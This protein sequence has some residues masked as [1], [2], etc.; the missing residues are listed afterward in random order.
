VAAN[1]QLVLLGGGGHCRSC[2]D[3]VEAH[4]GWTI[5]GI[6]DVPARI[7]ERVF[8][9]EI[10]GSDE[11]IGQ[12]AKRGIAFFVT[13]GQI[14]SPDR[15][16]ALYEK[17]RA[18]AGKMPTLVSPHAYVSPRAKL[19]SGTVVM[20]HATVNCGAVVGANVIVNSMAL[21]EHDAQIGDH[22]HVSTAALVNG[23]A[24]VGARTFIGSNAV[25]HQGARVPEDSIIA[26]GSVFR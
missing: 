2:I 3:V 10:I 8:D 5:A 26:A 13:I 19:G 15:R 7:G 21:I 4:G 6:L 20:H 12:F 16:V 18:V 22:C 1:N 9:Y 17:V 24:A 11:D 14:K 23:G 25:L